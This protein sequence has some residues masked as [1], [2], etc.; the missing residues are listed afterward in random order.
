MMK[1]YLKI[2]M[3]FL[4]IACMCALA[5]CNGTDEKKETN[6]TLEK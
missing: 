3:L 4:A 1:G 6:P 5:A 2:V